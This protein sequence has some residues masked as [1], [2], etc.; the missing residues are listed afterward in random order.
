MHTQD[1]AALQPAKPMMAR[2]GAGYGACFRHHRVAMSQPAVTLSQRHGGRPMVALQFRCRRKSRDGTYPAAAG[3]RG[4]GTVFGRLYPWSA[5]E[6]MECYELPEL[7]GDRA[8]ARLLNS[9]MRRE[10]D[11]RVG[12]AGSSRLSHDGCYLHASVSLI[13]SRATSRQAGRGPFAVWLLVTPRGLL[14]SLDFFR[15]NNEKVAWEYGTGP[16]REEAAIHQCTGGEKAL[17]LFHR[18]A[19]LSFQST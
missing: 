7:R 2:S 17:R 18:F 6:A 16:T 12:L 13:A 19:F 1:A 5:D 14:P 10:A 3:A 4:L 9:G 11:G 8:L 15:H